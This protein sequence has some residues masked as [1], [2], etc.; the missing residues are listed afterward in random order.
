M[1]IGTLA[2]THFLNDITADGPLLFSHNV[3]YDW[4][5]GSRSVKTSAGCLSECLESG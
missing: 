5:D 4:V 1:I 2:T 3:I